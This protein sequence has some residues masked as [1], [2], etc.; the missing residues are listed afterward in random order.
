[1]GIRPRFYL[2]AI[3]VLLL[4]PGCGVKTTPPKLPPQLQ[5]PFQ[6]KATI[7]YG[8]LSISALL[9]KEKEDCFRLEFQ[10]PDVLNGMSMSF[11]ADQITIQYRGL[12]GSYRP[13]SLPQAAVGQLLAESIGTVCQGEKLQLSLNESVLHA[14]VVL[15]G[16]EDSFT[17]TMDA[18]SGILQTLTIPGQDFQ[19]TFQEFS[20]Q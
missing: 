8:D 9:F 15:A 20:F 1:M 16:K 18:Q 4:L 5:Q 6:A 17:V 14:E 7:E 12:T 10:S 3:L 13:G 2:L 19:V 11:E